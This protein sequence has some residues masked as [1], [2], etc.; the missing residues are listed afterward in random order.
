MGA[1]GRLSRVRV[2][3]AAICASPILRNQ[4][5]ANDVLNLAHKVGVVAP[6]RVGL[7][8]PIRRSSRSPSSNVPASDVIAP[9]SN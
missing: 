7:R 3:T 4:L 9:P 5:R 2:I 6:G 8:G 1:V